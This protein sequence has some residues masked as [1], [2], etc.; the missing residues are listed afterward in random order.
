MNVAEH[1]HL[2]HLIGGIA[3]G[4]QAD[5]LVLPDIR[6]IQPSTVISMGQVVAHEGDIKVDPR[7]HTYSPG[8]MASIRLT[9]DMHAEDFAIR[10]KNSE[11]AVTVCVIQMVTDLVT[12]A[13]Y[14]EVP[15]IDGVIKAD[16]DRNIVK[17][18]AVART[19]QPGKRFTGLIKGFNLKSGAMA[20]SAAWD[21]AVIIV[22]GASD[23]D[24]ALAVNRIRGLNGGAVVC[25]NGRIIAELALPIFGLM[26]RLSVTALAK[27]EDDITRAAASLGVSF[28]NPFLSLVT[29]TGAAIPFLRICEEGLVN[30]KDGRQV[31]LIH[32]LNHAGSS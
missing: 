6:T 1:F 7:Q 25:Q 29:L 22:V 24:M 23:E 30:L 15:V 11:R 8:S 16:P 20:C 9:R 19:H 17:V 5:L 13:F 21:S 4:R 27:A 31:E 3:P 10:V 14:E 12:Q 26:S 18:T 32:A 28:P 2:D